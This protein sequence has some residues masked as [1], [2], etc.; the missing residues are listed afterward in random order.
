MMPKGLMPE[1]LTEGDC[2]Q[3]LK[4]SK[5]GEYELHPLCKWASRVGIGSYHLDVED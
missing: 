1:D 2:N 3:R 5:A 4:I